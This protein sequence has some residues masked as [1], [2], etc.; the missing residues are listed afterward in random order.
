MK[1]VLVS[2]LVHLVQKSDYQAYPNSD[3]SSHTLVEPKGSCISYQKLKGTPARGVLTEDAK[4]LSKPV[5][6]PITF[7]EF[8]CKGWWSRGEAF[9]ARFYLFRNI[10]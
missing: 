5:F 8:G 10:V 4:G 7:L 9:V 3:M 6:E 2:P 1:S